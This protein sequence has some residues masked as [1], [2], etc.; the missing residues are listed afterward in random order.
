[1]KLQI[2][3]FPLLVTLLLIFNVQNNGYAQHIAP[4]DIEMSQEFKMP[5]KSFLNRIISA[6]SKKAYFLRTNYNNIA[7]QLKSVI[8]ESYDLNTL[9]LIEAREIDLKYQKKLRVFHDIFEVNNKFYLITSFFNSGKNKNFLFAQKLN[10][11]FF[12]EKDLALIGEIDSKNE[13][14]SG[15]FTIEHSRDSSKVIIYADLPTKRSENYRAKISV[16]DDNFDLMWDKKINLPVETKLY[17]RKKILVDDKGDAYVLAKRFFDKNREA[18]NNL[19]NYEYLLEAYS[20][21]GEK[22]DR[23]KLCLLYTSDAADE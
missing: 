3:L 18:Q 13:F 17:D 5:N 6:D 22:L 11:K 7:G 4:A 9:K 23:Y 1:M 12:P 21:K 16:F 8:V 15:D 14:R 2:K 19:P 10:A 20:E